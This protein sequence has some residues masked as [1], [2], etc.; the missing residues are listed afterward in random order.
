MGGRSSVLLTALNTGLQLPKVCGLAT[1]PSGCFPSYPGH[2][3]VLYDPSSFDFLSLCFSFPGIWLFRLLPCVESLPP[4]HS[5]CPG[6]SR[7]SV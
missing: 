1:P 7:Q 3:P 4:R 5:L 2:P 6:T